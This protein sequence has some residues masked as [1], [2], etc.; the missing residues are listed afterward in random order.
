MKNS[1]YKMMFY[2]KKMA[3]VYDRILL[4]DAP[5]GIISTTCKQDMRTRNLMNQHCDF[6]VGEIHLIWQHWGYQRVAAV[7]SGL[8]SRPMRN[9]QDNWANHTQVFKIQS[10]GLW[11][12][13]DFRWKPMFRRK[14]LPPSSGFSKIKHHAP[15]KLWYVHK[16]TRDVT[17]Q[18]IGHTLNI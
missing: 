2:F 6:I 17:M 13:V 7:L 10:S 14:I 1:G 15:Y 11:H 3:R 9:I 4:V 5:I 18:K 8:K 16:R 12:H